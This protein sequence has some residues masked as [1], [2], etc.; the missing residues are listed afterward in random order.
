MNRKTTNTILHDDQQ[1]LF[2][3]ITE[4]I[5]NIIKTDMIWDNILSLSG[6]AGT[7]KT[8]LTAELVKYFVEKKFSVAVTTPTHRALK[9]IRDNL[10]LTNGANIPVDF[11]TIHSFLN[12]KLFTDYSKGVQKFIVDKSSTNTSIVDLLIVDESSMVSKELYNY[13]VD[14]IEAGRAKA[15][16]FVGDK[17][18]LL[19]IDDSEQIFDRINHNYELTKIVR[20]AEDSYIIK[21]A[22]QAREIIKSKRHMLIKDFFNTNF[23]SKIEF[24]HTTESFYTDFYKNK[25]WFNED[26][27]IA[28]F[29]NSDVDAHNRH[30]RREYWRGKGYGGTIETLMV[31]DSLVLQDAYT[32]AGMV[33]FNNGTEITLSYAKK[34]Y[35]EAIDVYFW[36]CIDLNGTALKV[37]D[38]DSQLRFNTVLKKVAENAKSEK[39]FH[40]RKELWT[41]FFDLK[42]L[43]AN[44]KYKFASTIHKLQGSTFETVYIDLFNLNSL[45]RTNKDD[46]FRLIYV[47]MTRASMN[48]KILVPSLNIQDEV[49]QI[50]ASVRKLFD[51]RLLR[52][53]NF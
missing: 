19:P 53:F 40:K 41:L 48:I 34:E 29:K 18:Q 1:E 13:I 16:L 45:E 7:G 9:I 50:N 6:A 37:V 52:D 36:E 2:T 31:G 21:I 14:A 28:S 51:T 49:Q 3:A 42:N 15:V 10:A 8:F 43:F 20:Q 26:K 11:S 24:F 25:N 33:V 47:A 38:I 35:M 27:V 12:I 5:E 39:N 32:K 23:D 17:Y 46:L 22:T 44:V 30:I 4:S